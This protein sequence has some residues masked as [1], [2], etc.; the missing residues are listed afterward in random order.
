MV[1]AWGMCSGLL[2]HTTIAAGLSAILAWSAVAFPVVKYAGA[3]YLIYLGVR[4]LLSK[5]EVTP[6]VKEAP[7]TRLWR[8]LLGG[9]TMNLLNPKVAVFF[10]LSCRGSRVA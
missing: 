2:L 5:E 7:T 4:A 9:L 10:W 1:S 6:A 3:V 8:F